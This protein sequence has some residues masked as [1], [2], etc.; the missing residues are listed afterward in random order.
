MSVESSY[1]AI[2]GYDLTGYETDKFDNWKWTG[3]G[4][5]YTCNQVA[6]KIQFFYDPMNGLHLYFGYI[7]GCGNQY[8][9]D[10]V[11]VDLDNIKNKVG[12]VADEL[13]KLQKLGVIKKDIM[14]KC[15]FIMFEECY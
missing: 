13:V 10:T 14:E 6:D 9:M 8:E 4:E 5:E 7:L 12:L 15:Q 2:V 11:K 3:E 1:Y